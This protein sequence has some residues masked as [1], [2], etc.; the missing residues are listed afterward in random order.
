M[1]KVRLHWTIDDKGEMKPR[2]PERLRKYLSGFKSGTELESVF[3]QTTKKASN[4]QYAYYFGHLCKNVADKAELFRGWTFNEI[5]DYFRDSFLSSKHMN[6]YADGTRK[7]GK[8]IRDLAQL[9]NIEMLEFTFQV[10]YFYSRHGVEVGGR[11]E[12]IDP[13]F[14]TKYHG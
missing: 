8:R 1:A 5:D 3:E 4:D 9:T 2:E 7:E 14:N 10:E 11:D 12:Y 6:I 13:S